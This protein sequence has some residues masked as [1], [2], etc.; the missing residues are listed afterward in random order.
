LNIKRPWP[1]KGTKTWRYHPKFIKQMLYTLDMITDF[2]RMYLQQNDPIQNSEAGSNVCLKK[3][4]TN[5]FLS[6]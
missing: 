4:S 6:L 2:I 3:P 5:G 1:Q